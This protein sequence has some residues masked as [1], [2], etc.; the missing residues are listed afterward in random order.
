[1]KQKGFSLIELLVVVAIIGILAAV[2]VVAYKGYNTAAIVVATK[3]NHINVV[4]YV[5]TVLIKCQIDPND[6]YDM[7]T[8]QSGTGKLEKCSKIYTA[9]ATLAFVE[10]TQRI[11]LKNHYNGY[12]CCGH[13]NNRNPYLGETY[14]AD[15]G[16]N[17]I[18]I[19]TNYK[20]GDP[21]IVTTLKI[22]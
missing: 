18:K 16:S 12:G 4:S 21:I 19:K 20:K 5:S 15:A 6:T 2:G 3:T 10:W 7:G 14:I 8:D 13:A 9:D 22:E 11:G 17:I 1:M